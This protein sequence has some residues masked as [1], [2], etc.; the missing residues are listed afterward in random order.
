MPLFLYVFGRASKISM[1]IKRLF[2]SS[3]CL[4]VSRK[5]NKSVSRKSED[6]EHVNHEFMSHASDY[7]TKDSI[8]QVIQA[9]WGIMTG[10][11]T[12]ERH[13]LGGKNK[14]N[15]IID[16]FIGGYIRILL[17]LLT[18]WSHLLLLLKMFFYFFRD[19]HWNYL[20]V[21]A[22]QSTNTLFLWWVKG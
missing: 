10:W 16:D 14:I 7:T 22:I 20:K 4:W 8:P 3:R 13:I 1:L 19:I 9:C 17:Y 18:F 15:F 21:V 2:T 6:S 11:M 5:L 12:N